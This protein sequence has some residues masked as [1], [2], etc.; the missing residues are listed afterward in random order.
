MG[1]ILFKMK[2]EEGSPLFYI[3]WARVGGFLPGVF[4]GGFSQGVPRA[5]SK[6]E[7]K[8]LLAPKIISPGVQLRFLIRPHKYS[9]ENICSL[10]N[11]F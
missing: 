10:K 3:L 1:V 7:I 6:L 5:P 4:L 11:G 2:R 9:P 8:Q